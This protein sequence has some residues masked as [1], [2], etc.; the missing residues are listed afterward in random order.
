[1]D[2]IIG[3]EGNGPANGTSKRAEL[4][5]VSKDGFALDIVATNIMGYETLKLAFVKELLSRKINPFPVQQKGIPKIKVNF[6]KP[7]DI[8]DKVPVFL[9]KSLAS[10]M[11]KDP[12][13]DPERCRRCMVCYSHCPAKTI[14]IYEDKEK[15]DRGYSKHLEI[16]LNKCIHCFCCH[17]LCPHD[18]IDLRR[19]RLFNPFNIAKFFRKKNKQ[20]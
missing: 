7:L 11:I 2:G 6:K 18:A 8:A 3:M 20:K 14:H 5:L 1:M 15:N 13:I 12:V 19:K 10:V 4:I 16:S 9:K 17:E